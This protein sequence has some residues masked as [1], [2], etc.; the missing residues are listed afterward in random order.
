MKKIYN[1]LFFLLAAF[2][3]TSC[4]SEVD[5]V[6]DKSSADRIAEAMAA[7]QQMLVDAPNGWL[8]EYFCEDT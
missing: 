4:T 1:I 5:N 8:M 2:T 6:F 3:Y 7:D